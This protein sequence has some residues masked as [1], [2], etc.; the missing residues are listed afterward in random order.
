MT[1]SLKGPPRMSSRRRLDLSRLTGPQLLSISLGLVFVVLAIFF[2]L[3]TGEIFFTPR[4]LSLLLRQASIVAVL[5]AGACVLMVMREI[6]LSAGSSVFLC[7]VASAVLTVQWGLPT[8]VAVVAAIVLGLALGLWQGFWVVRF[9]IPSFIVTLAG[10]LAFRGIGLVWTNSSTVGPVPPELQ[11]LSEAFIPPNGSIGLIVVVFVAVVG[12]ALRRLVLH[13]SEP[14]EMRREDIV[15]TATQLGVF[16]I[17]LG[18]LAWAAGGFLGIPFTLMW[19]VAVGVVL[20]F[21]MSR[22]TFGRNAYL[23]GSNREAAEF[24]GISVKKHIFGGF[25]IMGALYGIGG[26]LL[27]ARLSAASPS[28]GTNLELDAIAAAVIG[29]TALVGGVGTIPGAMIGALLLAT[30]DN[31]MSLMNV[32]SSAQLIVKGL[33][34]L[35]ALGINAYLLRRR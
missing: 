6:D 17:G 25:L 13:R 4:N 24:A 7:G 3:Q 14:A 29:G 31:G 27:T 23:I 20:W 19:S 11:A 30:I 33:V 15:R 34:L 8:S 5:A 16:A 12:L 32:S 28:S 10:L 26:V 1:A 22:S 9:G 18:L 35:G 2:H 21:V